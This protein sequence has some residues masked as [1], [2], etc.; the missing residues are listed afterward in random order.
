MT[1]DIKNL[2]KSDFI[3]QAVR[4]FG[5][6][7]EPDETKAYLVDQLLENIAGRVFLEAGRVIPEDKRAEFNTLAESGEPDAIADFLAPYIS[8]FPGFV[9]AEA[10]KEIDQTRSYMLEESEAALT[11]GGQ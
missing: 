8:D 3:Q 7:G 9:R 1:I 2:L 5:I 4:L 11:G 10:Q 6:D